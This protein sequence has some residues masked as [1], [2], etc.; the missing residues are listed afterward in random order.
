MIYCQP[1][2]ADFLKF[3]FL[4]LFYDKC[5]NSDDGDVRLDSNHRRTCSTF[6][7]W[8]EWLK[9]LLLLLLLLGSW[10]H[11]CYWCHVPFR[12]SYGQSLP[13]S[14]LVS[15]ILLPV[16]DYPLLLNHS[17]LEATSLKFSLLIDADYYL[18]SIRCR[19]LV[20]H[21]SFVFSRIIEILRRWG[22]H[23]SNACWNYQILETLLYFCWVSHHHSRP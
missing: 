21:D 17:W 6:A 4:S 10:N 15:K 7:L 22:L 3:T 13:P 8:I 2:I 18:F 19:L 11:I 12:K 16:S 5:A 9:G 23:C 20:G 1:F 14:F